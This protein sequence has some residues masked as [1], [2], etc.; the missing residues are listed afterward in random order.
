MRTWTEEEIKNLVQTN[1]E[2]L[3]RALIQLYNCQ[4]E[5]E[6]AVGTTKEYN[7]AGFNGVDAPILSSFATFYKKTGFLT[8]KQKAIAR[9]KLIKYNK[10]LTRIANS[11]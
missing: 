9:R 6:K 3:Y 1:D 7:N 4:T 8:G 2:V 11:N 5:D 10:Q